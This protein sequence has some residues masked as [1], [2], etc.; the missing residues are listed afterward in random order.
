M[1]KSISLCRSNLSR[2][3]LLCQAH[4]ST[5]LPQSK[6]S[7]IVGST[8]TPRHCRRTFVSASKKVK[9]NKHDNVIGTIEVKPT[10]TGT[11]GSWLSYRNLALGSGALIVAAGMGSNLT[12]AALSESSSATSTTTSP[13]NRYERKLQSLQSPQY[14][15]AP[16]EYTKLKR[17]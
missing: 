10:S 15:E 6:H 7:V 4:Y 14:N 3:T 8:S 2:R 1:M 17:C 5:Q 13:G 16:N 12:A 9:N 11:N